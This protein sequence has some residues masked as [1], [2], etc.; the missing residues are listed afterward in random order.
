MLDDRRIGVIDR[1]EAFEAI[2][3]RTGV[4]I[5]SSEN[6]RS[7]WNICPAVLGTWMKRNRLEMEMTQRPSIRS[8]QPLIL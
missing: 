4:I 3:N 2:L 8:G 1:T 5:R 7:T 6:S